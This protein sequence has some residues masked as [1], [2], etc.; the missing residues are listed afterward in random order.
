MNV[1]KKMCRRDV[2]VGFVELLIEKK[3]AA[4]KMLCF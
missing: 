3:D 4:L 1:T 2:G